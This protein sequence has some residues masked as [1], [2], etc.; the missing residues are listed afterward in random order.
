MGVI[1]HPR[2]DIEKIRLYRREKVQRVSAL[3]PIVV[4]LEKK[5]PVERWIF[6][7]VNQKVVN[8][9]TIREISKR[10]G[11]NIPQEVCRLLRR[12]TGRRLRR[13]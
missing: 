3:S 2:Y 4:K 7:E 13:S 9:V 11:I 1:S 6:L 10:F 8:M 5:K 12:P